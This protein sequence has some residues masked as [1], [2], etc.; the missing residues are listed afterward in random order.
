MDYPTLF[1]CHF[2]D[3]LLTSGR[4]GLKVRQG[5]IFYWPPLFKHLYFWSSLLL[6]IYVM[7]LQWGPKTLLIDNKR[8]GYNFCLKYRLEMYMKLFDLGESKFT[9]SVTYECNN[10]DWKNAIKLYLK[11]HPLLVTLYFMN[12]LALFAELSKFNDF[13]LNICYSY[14][15]FR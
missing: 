12:I 13:F 15:P 11:S 2:P 8:L 9:A 4:T 3:L 1:Y 14:P 10:E 7:R 6:T 5:Y